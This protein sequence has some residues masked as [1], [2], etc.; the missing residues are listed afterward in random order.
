MKKFSEYIGS[1]FGNPRGAMGKI[2]CLIMNVINRK[3]YKKIIRLA[4][5]PSGEKI[6]DIGYGNGYMLRL[7]DK[8]FSSDMYGVDI[9][10]DMKIKA[11]ASNRN[12]A[13]ENRLHLQI[14][15]C[16]RLPY[17]DN[18][19]K[20]VSSV[21]TVYFW[22]DTL[23]GFSEIH[24]CLKDGGVFYNAVYAKEWLDRLSYTKK[25]FQKFTPEQLKEFGYRA[26]FEKVEIEQIHKG[27][28]YAVICT[29]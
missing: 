9:S 6:L 1:Q 20:A 29:K 28:S 16:C 10:E 15:D 21:N 12:A 14:G 13:K 23:K 19:F 5:I 27:K 18:M 17:Q 11:T 25:G 22:S 3:M 26:G 8:A 2:C 24:R 7:M 4:D